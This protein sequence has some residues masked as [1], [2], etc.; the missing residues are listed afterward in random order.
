MSVD[1]LFPHSAIADFD[2]VVV[3]TGEACGS[4]DQYIEL[5]ARLV[6]VV[7]VEAC[8]DLPEYRFD[9]GKIDNLWLLRLWSS[10]GIK[11][12]ELLDRALREHGVGRPLIWVEDP[13]WSTYVERRASNFVI[14]H[15]AAKGGIG[16][17]ANTSLC[18][19][20]QRL[21]HWTDLLISASDEI[22]QARSPHGYSGAFVDASGSAFDSRA[23][24]ELLN[25][26]SAEIERIRQSP[27]RFNLLVLYDD[28]S[29][30]VGTIREHLSSFRQYSK[31]NV[32]YLPG[33]R[34]PGFAGSVLPDAW[35]LSWFDAIILH[36]SIRLSLR[37]HL[38]ETLAGAIENFT[39][40]KMAFIQD[41]YENTEIA[42][43]WIERL[44]FDIVF[45]C[46][47]AESVER[48]YPRARFPGTRFIQKLT[49]YVPEDEAL[50]RFALPL[51]Q[52]PV[53]IGYRGRDLPH[54]Y[55]TLG[56]DKYRIG[57]DVRHLAQQR[58]IPVDI[59]VASEKRVYGT[60]WYRF[61]G[62]CRAML[63]TESGSNIFDHDGSLATL[64]E[65]YSDRPY[66]EIYPQYLA[67][68]EGPV[69]MNQISPK[70]FEAI[71][72]RTALVLFEG[73]Y[74]GVL[75]PQRH[76]IPLKKDY[77]NMDE[78]FA[79]ISDLGYL[80]RLTE[81]AFHEII[82]PGRYSYKKF[83][84]AVDRQIDQVI[85][86]RP[87]GELISAPLFRRR[88]GSSDLL[89]VGFCSDQDALLNTAIL[90][91]NAVRL[92]EAGYSPGASLPRTRPDRPARPDWRASSARWI[93]RR[94]PVRFR[95]HTYQ[96]LV[97]A[98]TWELAGAPAERGATYRMAKFAWSILPA[99][100]R[101]SLLQQFYG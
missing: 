25:R 74:S 2:S 87:R 61:V 72:L 46:V 77:S 15:A 10:Y 32:F 11:Q 27:R 49:G 56:R 40:L 45:T 30:H 42:R 70:A 13:H 1:G 85:V 39:G 66:D 35:D 88:R 17:I 33:S 9:T 31:N 38:P 86:Q 96:A 19:A 71:R 101:R 69:C 97:S 92:R 99:G 82:E 18:S 22:R 60:E 73:D 83:V 55:G 28:R 47:P 26:I 75:E 6:P 50:D 44:R 7:C 41:E 63:G 80:R 4:T 64:A 23:F 95:R 81:R 91:S 34:G 84:E 100:M 67:M 29:S 48:V 12:S 90:D 78:V 54:H 58:G 14:Y 65:R 59:E 51:E 53:H 89:P 16:T 20:G 76:Y 21:L 79:K 62:S 52:R 36:Y 93:W 37:E 43:R 24:A 57:V 94:L 98:T 3:L 5:F 68:H 8:L